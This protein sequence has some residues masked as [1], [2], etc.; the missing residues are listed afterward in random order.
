MQETITDN[1]YN[2]PKYYDLIFGSDWAAEYHF[3]QACFAKHAKREVKRLLE[4]A[5]GTGRLLVRLGEAGYETFGLDLSPLAVEFCN[6][7][8]ER[9]GFPRAA[10]VADMSDF[11]LK[12]FG[13]A[14]KFD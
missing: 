5:C 10:I 14:R 13:S 3:F 7:R 12:D 4:P 8:F 6:K 11:S 2:Y 1:V 9:K